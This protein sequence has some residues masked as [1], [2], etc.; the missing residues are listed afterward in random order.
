MAESGE[1]C[2]HS[3]RHCLKGSTKEGLLGG[4]GVNVGEEEPCPCQNEGVGQRTAFLQRVNRHACLTQLEFEIVMNSKC[5]HKRALENSVS[6]II[7]LG[8]KRNQMV[9]LTS[10]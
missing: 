3:I 10:A 6:L 5:L 7:R 9:G 4:R 8:L 1:N 2:G